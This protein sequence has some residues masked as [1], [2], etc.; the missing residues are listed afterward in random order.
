MRL[1]GI[2]NIFVIFTAV[3]ISGSV[4]YDRLGPASRTASAVVTTKQRL[5]CKRF[6]LPIAAATDKLGT[7]ATVVLIIS[8]KCH[9]CTES[10]PFYSQLTA[11]KPLDGSDLA[12][13]AGF[14]AGFETSQQ[15][16][17]HFRQHGA[18][19]D[20]AEPLDFAAIGPTATPTI[21]LLDQ[22]GAVMNVWV[23]KLTGNGQKDVIAAVNALYGRCRRLPS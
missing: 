12:I 14:P 16:I 18:V 20:A 2:A 17:D 6:S 11:L 15:T 9:F 23:G 7:A 22:S 13:V 5:V 8:K 4:L 21:L 1:N 10:M 3:I 19:P